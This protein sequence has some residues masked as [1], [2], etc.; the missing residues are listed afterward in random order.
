MNYWRTQAGAAEI[1]AAQLQ[2][3]TF[4]QGL[5]PSEKIC[6]TARWMKLIHHCK[7][8]VQGGEHINQAGLL[9]KPLKKVNWIRN[10]LVAVNAYYDHHVNNTIIPKGGSKEQP[11][12]EII[13][14]SMCVYVVTYCLLYWDSFCDIF[15]KEEIAMLCDKTASPKSTWT[16]IYGNMSNVVDMLGDVHAYGV[17]T[18]GEVRN[19]QDLLEGCYD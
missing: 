17:N 14:P 5:S 11:W 10:Q 9:R 12:D 6:Y 19:A 18:S 13:T 3:E 16:K 8:I 7:R 1:V 2:A 4:L 15:G